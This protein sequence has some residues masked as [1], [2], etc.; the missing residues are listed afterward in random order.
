MAICQD[1]AI[2]RW[3]RVPV[4]TRAPTPRAWIAASELELA[5]GT[6][7]DWLAVD[8]QDDVVASVAIQDIR[9]DRG[10]RRDR[11]LGRGARTR[12]RD[13]HPR[14]PPR[15]RWA[16]DE[17]GL[18]TLEIMAH[19]DNPASQGVARAA[20]FEQTGERRAPPREGLAP[21]RYVV[22]TSAA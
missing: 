3:T 14:R 17:L 10:Q 11:L 21:G 8:E 16:R 19:E 5:A 2:P 12:P 9:G 4:P 15:G 22:F 13:R 20:G 18:R 1:P 6:A 7:I